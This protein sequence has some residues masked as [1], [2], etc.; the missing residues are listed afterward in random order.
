MSKIADQ[1]YAVLDEMFPP[2]PHKRVFREIYV[3][4]RGNKLYFDFYIKEL[5]L[6]VEVQGRQHVEF[7]KHFHGSKE[8]FNQQKMR[9]N[10]KI[11]YVNE[12]DEFSLV[13]FY[14]NEKITKKLVRNKICKVLEGECFYE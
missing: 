1:I 11:S 4:Y 13:R 12:S 7:V 14:Y 9:D 2:M 8:N 3:N 10:L 5:K 6:Y